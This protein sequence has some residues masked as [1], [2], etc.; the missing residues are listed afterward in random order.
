VTLEAVTDVFP[1]T[2]GIENAVPSVGVEPAVN[3]TVLITSVAAGRGRVLTVIFPCE[4]YV[5]V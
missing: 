5:T 4:S 1:V 3:V 2:F